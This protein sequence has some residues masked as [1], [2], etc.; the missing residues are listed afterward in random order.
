VAK[1][2]VLKFSEKFAKFY[3]AQDCRGSEIILRVTAPVKSVI[4][5][6]IQKLERCNLLTKLH[7]NCFNINNT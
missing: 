5:H 4:R 2:I 7:E 6:A 1:D 3:L